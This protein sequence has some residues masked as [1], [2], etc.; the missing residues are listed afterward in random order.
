MPVLF[1]ALVALA[2]ITR[3][4]DLLFVVLSWIFVVSR[5]VHAA[6]Y[7]TTNHVPHRFAAYLV[8][9]VTLIILWISF[10]ARILV[11]PLPA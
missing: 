9:A 11:V 7:V 2:I 4:A 8:G 1:Y 5:L 6:V 10:A 3:K